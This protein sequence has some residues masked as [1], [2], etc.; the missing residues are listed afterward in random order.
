MDLSA[1][2]ADDLRK[3]MEYSAIY[4]GL[5]MYAVSN[6]VNS[7]ACNGLDGANHSG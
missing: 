5:S 3:L 2:D 6:A 1:K 7:A 4:D